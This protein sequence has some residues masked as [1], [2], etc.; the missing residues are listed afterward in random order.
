MSAALVAS[1]GLLASAAAADE[2]VPLTLEDALAI[3]GRA[4]PDLRATQERS[5]AAQAR[6]AAAGRALWPQLSAS[7]EWA[8]T[9]TAARVFASKLNRGQFAAEDFAIDRLNDP[10]PLSHLATSILLEA[11]L[12]VFGATRAE[13]RSVAAGG[14]ASAALAAEAAQELRLRVVEAYRRLVL[15]RVAVGTTRRVLEGARAREADIAAQTSEGIALEAD[16]LRARARRRLREADV[17]ERQGELQIAQATLGRLL[18]A[19]AGTSFEATEPAPAPPP[20]AADLSA[21]VARAVTARGAPQAARERLESARW[22]ERAARRSWLP[23]V[24]AYG[25][26][27]DDRGSPSDGRASGSLGVVLRWN[28]LD[29]SRGKRMAAAAAEA[30]ASAE[31]SRAAE[32]QVRLEVE[33]AF[34]RAETARQRYAAAAGGAAEGREALRVVQERRQAGRATLTDELETDAASLAAELEEIRAAAE[35]AIADA[36]LRRA[37]GEL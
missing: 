15:A 30:R 6:G 24:S 19:A 36:A 14:R 18:G 8:R 17:A 13:A 27:Q 9:D 29:P 37:A 3:A 4:N 33:M 20:L 5:H 35:A 22:A 10:A 34:R 28:L 32:D 1:V 23:D 11:P 31:E 12:D 25:Q 16:H 26:L 2:P 7:S 21:W